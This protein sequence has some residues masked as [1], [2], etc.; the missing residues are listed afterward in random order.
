MVPIIVGVALNGE[1]LVGVWI[2]VEVKPSP[3][4][5]YVLSL[6]QNPSFRVSMK[7][8]V[9]TELRTEMFF[10]WSLVPVFPS[11]QFKTSLN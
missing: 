5:N 6:I 11:T 9:K 3:A 1:S 4:S 8:K 2:G 10:Y 7:A